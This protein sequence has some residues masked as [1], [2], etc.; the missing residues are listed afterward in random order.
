MPYDLV[1][2]PDTTSQHFQDA[3]YFD[4]RES[5]SSAGS[6]RGREEDD[7]EAAKWTE[8]DVDTIQAVSAP[9]SRHD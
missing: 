1:Q 9:V 8:E 2:T 5:I 7:E 4:D 3:M 6:K